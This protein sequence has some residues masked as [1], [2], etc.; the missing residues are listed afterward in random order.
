[1]AN[2]LVR[3]VPESVR[4][5]LQQRAQEQGQSLQQFLSLELRRLADR[6]LLDT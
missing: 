2:I 6:T 1:M 5:T 3:D 4:A